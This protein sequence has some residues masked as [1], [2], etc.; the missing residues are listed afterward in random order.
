MKR[1]AHRGIQTQAL[2]NTFA[3]AQKT[4]L[5]PNVAGLEIDVRLTL[6]KE[7]VV[8]HDPT[9]KRMCGLHEC[10]SHVVYY[11]LPPLL[12]THPSRQPDR[13]P[14]L[15][16]I[17]DILPA[18]KELWLDL[19]GH[20]PRLPEQVGKLLL[21]Y[22]RL[23]A[24]LR[25]LLSR[26]EW[27]PL[28]RRHLPSVDI[29]LIACYSEEYNTCTPCPRTVQSDKELHDFMDDALQ[30]GVQSIGL[31]WSPFISAGIVQLVHNRGLKLCLW[32]GLPPHGLVDRNTAETLKIDYITI[33][34]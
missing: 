6:D 27:T 9:L 25:I 10:L 26:K 24:N 5:D 3:A 18:D 7:L 2:E 31:E 21:Q 15:Q 4:F 13:I 33:N 17:L 1:I 11:A 16:E 30:Q 28:L 8:F 14:R 20:D 19:K 22:P 29:Q 12:D 32:E 23:H 34:I